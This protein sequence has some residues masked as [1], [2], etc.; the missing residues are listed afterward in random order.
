M[1]VFLKVQCYVSVFNLWNRA[2]GWCILFWICVLLYQCSIPANFFWDISVRFLSWECWDF[3]RRHNRFQI[4]PKNSEGGVRKG[5]RWCGFAL[6]LVRFC[7]N[8]YF[9]SR[10]CGFKTI[11]G[12]RLLQPL[13]LS[14]Q[15]K[16][17]PAVMTLF[18]TVDFLLFCKREPSVL[19]YNASRFILSVY[20]NYLTLWFA[21]TAFSN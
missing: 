12:L 16:K 3:R 5:L 17:V 6:F 13:G 14:F 21:I 11:S 8:S 1:W 9:N 20:N 2:C 7:G 10:Y 19:L 4:L 15:W 18:R